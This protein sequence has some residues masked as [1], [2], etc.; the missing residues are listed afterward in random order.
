MSPSTVGV[1]PAADSTVVHTV[2][3]LLVRRRRSLASLVTTYT[4]LP[5]TMA[6]VPST[7]S[8]GADQIGARRLIE[9]FVIAVS[10]LAWPLRRS[11]PRAVSQ[12]SPGAADA[13]PAPNATTTV[14]RAVTPAMPAALPALR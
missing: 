10:F 7:L 3:P 13:L 9:D 6:S 1:S 12:L 2:E 4:A 5:L 14:A 8:P 11:L